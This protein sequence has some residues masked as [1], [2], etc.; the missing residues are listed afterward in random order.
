MIC[1]ESQSIG[2][3][4]S[5]KWTKRRTPICELSQ[6][7]ISGTDEDAVVVQHIFDDNI[8]EI[9][10]NVLYYISGFL[11]RGIIKNIDC[12]ECAEA[13]TSPRSDHE[14]CYLP[15]DH[16]SFVNR[17]D[18]G[19]LIYSSSGVYKVVLA[20][21]KSF[22]V[23]VLNSTT[24]ISVQSNLINR[25]VHEVISSTDWSRHFPS[26]SDHRFEI[27]VGFE[28]DHLTQVVKRVSSK[29]FNM[30]LHTYA[31]RYNREVVNHDTPSMRHQ[32]SKLILFKHI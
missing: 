32:L 9:T 19:G 12:Q 7:S 18:C 17:K 24:K 27:D 11:V 10:E 22:K 30:R 31:K 20:C 28:D 15:H 1:F 14:Y 16:M 5:L 4:F 13:L 25:M 2:S 3:L 21:E 6:G 8:S 23:N 29:Y 26:I